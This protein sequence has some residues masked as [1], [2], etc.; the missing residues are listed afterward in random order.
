MDVADC[1]LAK[2]TNY[3]LQNLPRIY[4][5]LTTHGNDNDRHSTTSEDIECKSDAELHE[6]DDRDNEKSS[7]HSDD[8]VIVDHDCDTFGRKYNS[9][10]LD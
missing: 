7:E 5:T 1:K 6:F 4:T 8:V 10:R 9:K 2:N 3:V